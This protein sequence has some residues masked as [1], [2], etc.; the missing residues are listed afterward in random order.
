[1][2]KIIPLL[3]AVMLIILSIPAAGAAELSVCADGSGVA[4][5]RSD[6]DLTYSFGFSAPQ[7]VQTE[8]IRRSTYDEVRAKGYTDAEIAGSSETDWLLCPIEVM[9]SVRLN[10]GVPLPVK[11]VNVTDGKI[12]VSLFKDILPALAKN[13]ALNSARLG[14]FDFEFTLKLVLNIN[15]NFSPLSDESDTKTPLHAPAT[16]F[17]DYDLPLDADNK[18]N[19]VFLFYPIA[20]DIILVNPERTGFTFTGWINA[21]GDAVDR[22]PAGTQYAKLGAGWK[23]RTFKVSYVLTTRTEYGFIKCKNSNPYTFSSET[24]LS[25]LD[26]VPP[27]G[28]VFA[29]WFDNAELKGDTLTGI[30]AGTDRDVILYAKW[31]TDEEVIDAKIASAKWGDLDSDG[32]ITAADARLALRASV[33]LEELSK[34]I[35][36]RADFAAQ[37]KL[38]AS[39]ARTLLRISVGLDGLKDV[40]KQYGLI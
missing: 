5:T 6:T 22:I 21:E 37:G 18:T 28:W 17:I 29:G 27:S 23:S 38:T 35:L 40:L 26:P 7:A 20:K 10:S 39:T 16:V 12:S 31:M 1:M 24:G 11:C 34:D 2:K 30:P 25:L 36:A 4:Q 15:G 14:G 13:D 32:K 33:G 3:T 9:C 8:I 19:P